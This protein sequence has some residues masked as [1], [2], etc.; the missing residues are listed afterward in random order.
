MRRK[1]FKVLIFLCFATVSSTAQTTVSVTVTDARNGV[2]IKIDSPKALPPP[3]VTQLL[4]AGSYTL[5]EERR[6]SPD[7]AERL[8]AANAIADASERFQRLSHQQ[9]LT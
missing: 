7:F 6:I 9:S 3:V 1:F 4:R 5:T 8:V 2:K